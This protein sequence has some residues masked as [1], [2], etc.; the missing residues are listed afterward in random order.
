MAHTKPF[1]NAAGRLFKL[2]DRAKK[3]PRGFP[4]YA[5]WRIVL[6][7]NEVANPG[8]PLSNDGMHA[9]GEHLRYWFGT[10]E[11]IKCAVQ[12]H[13]DHPE[14]YLS[15]FENLTKLFSP[16][17]LEIGFEY[18]LITPSLLTNLQHCA[19][20]LPEDRTI[21]P[22]EVQELRE[23]TRE[24]INQ[25]KD[26]ELPTNLR[27]W[28]VEMLAKV[29]DAIIHFDRFGGKGLRKAL[30]NLIGELI[31]DGE[32]TKSLDAIPTIKEKLSA[33]LG[34]I[35]VGCETVEHV[36]TLYELGKDGLT[37]YATYQSGTM[38]RPY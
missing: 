17:N 1:N 9:I 38:I 34:K 27:K 13:T 19:K 5:I 15:E 2:L 24:L 12:E 14:I 28:L 16:R 11:D 8:S 32:K 21:S 25:I 4:T 30:V 29:E 31:I 35:K 7:D 23:A 18:G 33:L 6:L 26:S 10:V 37:L 3:L 36:K 22:D 20:D